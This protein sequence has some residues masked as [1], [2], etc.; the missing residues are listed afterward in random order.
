MVAPAIHWPEI[1]PQPNF[2]QPLSVTLMCSV[3]SSTCCQYFAVMMWP[4]GCA[5]L[6][7]TAFASPVVPDV[8]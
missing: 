6:W 4:S 2:A 7:H 8:K 3:S 5:K 1:L